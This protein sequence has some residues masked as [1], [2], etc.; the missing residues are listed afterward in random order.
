MVRMIPSRVRNEGISLYEK[1]LVTFEK[2]EAKSLLFQV[3][4]VAL[5]FSSQ[6][7]ETHCQCDCFLQKQYCQH[8]AA[9]E[10]ALKNDKLL[11]HLVEQEKSIPEPVEVVASLGKLF[12]DQL[13]LT[14]D[15]ERDYRLSAFGE[16]NP[17]SSDFWWTLKINRLPDNRQYIIRDIKSFLQ[18]L[19]RKSHYQL[20]KQYFEP[21]SLENFDQAS[22]RLIE[23]LWRLLPQGQ[24]VLLDYYFP[25]Q[26]RHL[27]LP[28][29]VFE[30]GLLLLADL[31]D[32]SL[33]MDQ[34]NYSR[35][36]FAELTGNDGF[37]LFKVNNQE[38]QIELICEAL[39]DQLFF[40]KEY[41]WHQGT[42]YR[43]NNKQM[44]LLTAI[45]S[46][47]VI[48][49][50]KRMIS[51]LKSEQAQLAASLLAF[52]SLGQV[53]AP[54]EFV[55]KDFVPSFDLDIAND[56]RLVLRTVFDYGQ[57]V[58]HN[59]QDLSAL[60]FTS[61][62]EHEKAVFQTIKACGFIG[63]FT[64][65]HPPLRS[66]HLHQFFHQ[67]LP[68]LQQL[69]LVRLSEDLDRRKKEL[70]PNVL[71]D[72]QE[73]LLAISFDFTGITEDDVELAMSALLANESFFINQS[74]QLVEFDDMT[75]KI[76]QALQ[77]TSVETIEPGKLSLPI[78]SAFQLESLTRSMSR[79]NF[80]APFEQLA[81]DLRH[82]EELEL[83]ELNIKANL[84][85]YQQIG[86]K[87]L[88]ML[89]RYGFGGILADDMGL[90][91][92]L[93]T[94]AFLTSRMTADT[95]VLILAPSSL[96][97]N[98]QEEWARFAPDVDVAVAY[99]PK[100]LRDK[101]IAEGHQV[102]ISSYS[103]FRQDVLTYQAKQ[104]D[105][106]ILDEAQM[107][108]NNQ[109]KLAQQL[110]QFEVKRCFALSGTPIE[111]KLLE[112]WSIFQIVMP[113]LLPSRS[114]FL[115]WSAQM[116]ATRI[117]PFILRR[118]KEDVLPE[119]PNLIEI[120]HYN[121]LAD[122]QKSIYLAQLRQMQDQVAHTST[123]EFQAKKMEIL[124]G[125][126]RLRQ[127]CD[128][129]ALFMDYQGSSGKID[130]LIE[131]LIQL[132]KNQRRVLIFSQFK[133]MLDIIEG[134]LQDLS[135]SS[136]KLT[137]STPSDKRQNMTQQFNAG[138][139]DV[140]LISLKAGGVG[141]NLTGA[142]TVILVDLWWN[143]AVEM[144]AIGR[145]HRLGQERPVAVYRLITR[146]SIEEKILALQDRK[147]HL[148]TTVLDG[149]DSKTNLSLAEIKQILGLD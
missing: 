105:Y 31:Y 26:A 34:I 139:R 42:F 53:I 19:R 135:L 123:Q 133:G 121:E 7:S 30:Q 17:Y 81:Y 83:P 79:V 65:Y 119:L 131:L 33:E 25:N 36:T 98:W 125:L 90:G 44:R 146:G 74:G 11:Q 108:K 28:V 18:G 10:H 137:G 54:E 13:D 106:L 99:G 140:F 149:Q 114:K 20:G 56:G 111:N 27:S 97:Y 92:T 134:L 46:L 49:D 50:K 52:Q 8:L 59:R 95:R 143:P 75:Q 145:A 100:S 57:A 86:V 104:F 68:Q 77:V 80:S 41:L 47:P 38:N 32:F 23:F 118:K 112:I 120:T 4:Q 113:G 71:I 94:I 103:A 73:G 5:Q 21:L 107:M 115:S 55:I 110:R 39:T 22:Q 122:E 88:S 70:A 141:L 45:Q 66:S 29:S 142:D 78:L 96:I 6:E 130:S 101:I 14:Q 126:M 12:L 124:S 24:S 128:T 89:D 3:D 116:V 91:K 148:I 16:P 129:P 109:S 138:Q 60:P 82:P 63:D 72:Y 102:I 67:T 136:F 51:F 64:A 9:V 35:I 127:I 147:R 144:Q 37:Y 93:Q 1:G 85:D 15:S 132:K 48:D 117:S 2:E 69:G 61:H 43:L 62:F 87:W 84:R 40:D 76:S 58:V